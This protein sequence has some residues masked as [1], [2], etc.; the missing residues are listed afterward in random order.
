MFSSSSLTAKRLSLIFIFFFGFFILCSTAYAAVPTV[1]NMSVT[2][3]AGSSAQITLS[4]I[5]N[6]RNERLS[7]YYTNPKNGT[8]KRGSTTSKTLVVTYTPRS[9]YTGNDSFTYTA[10]DRTRQT[11]KSAMVTITVVAVNAAPLAYSQ[12]T[13]TNED[14]TMT[15]T[16]IA[17]DANNDS[18]TYSISTSPSHGSVV[19][20]GSQA[21]Y[22]PSADF[23]GS[24]SFT[25]VAK[26]NS[27]TSNQ[28]TVTITINAVN[29]S[30]IAQAATATMDGNTETDIILSANDVDSTILTY[31]IATQPQNGTVSISGAVAH[32]TPQI[33]FDGIDSFSYTASDGS[34][35]SD[36]AEVSV[37]VTPVEVAYD[38]IP[39]GAWGLNGFVSSSG[40]ADVSE[41][42]GFTLFQV[43]SSEPHYT[44]SSLLPLVRASG[45]Q[46]TLRMTGSQNT[47][48]TNGNFDIQKWKD[49]VTKWKT[50]CDADPS[51]CVQPYIDDGTLAGHMIL[52]DIFTYTGTDPTAAELD[53]MARYS[54]EI[55]PGLMT[56]VRNKASTMP[57]PDSGSYEYLDACVNQY[58]NFQGYSDGPIATYVAQQATAAASLGLDVINGLNIADGGDGSSGVRGWSSNNKYAMSP[59]E[60]TTYGTALLNRDAFPNLRLFLLW[61]YDGQELWSDG[62]T[63]GSD[64]FDQPE[65]QNAIYEL[66]L[67]ASGQ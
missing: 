11:S 67:E 14:T 10:R 50:A 31:S 6:D 52:D 25:F 16:L 12:S 27:A 28:A 37:T 20:S 47:Y 55:F 8:I 66:S 5:D 56:F 1:A 39:F 18:L 19:V 45:M 13:T 40:L 58:T 9:N 41:R 33:G 30:P 48:T 32:Y 43:A 63:I 15:T 54:Q 61:E 64:Y 53:E 26:D 17:S 22:T 21:S 24:D 62:I 51:D 29:D 23:N 35:I 42:F 46:V 4:G 38:P 60:I 57:V 65:L 2:V 49:G 59:T 3:N 7:F 34:A 44:V 36:A